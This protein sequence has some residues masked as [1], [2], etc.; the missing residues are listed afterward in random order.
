MANSPSAKPAAGS[1][2]AVTA[3]DEEWMDGA[4]NAFPKAE[5]L[6]PVNPPNFG[7]GRLV[8]IW[9]KSQGTRK[10]DKGVVY[11]FV[12][13]LTLVLDEGPDGRAWL[14]GSDGWDA[15]ASSLIPAS[16]VRLDDFQHSTSGL[17]AR[18]QK[19]LTGKN[20]AGVSLK[21]RPMVGRM[22]TQASKANSKVAA[23]SISE[24]TA[25]DMVKARKFKDMI[26]AIN[27]ELETAA[28]QAEDTAAFDE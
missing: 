18:L 22:N 8:A 19:R 10:N 15:E 11:P 21:F 20:A 9:A 28:T 13:T 4:S 23:F 26:T 24:P 3:E 12:N 27:K 1:D 2:K 14:T 17:V 5:H 7:P 16:P 6:A 25:D